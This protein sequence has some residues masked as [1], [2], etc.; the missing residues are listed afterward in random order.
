MKQIPRF[1]YPIL[2]KGGK[3]RN[4]K[5]DLTWDDAWDYDP[6]TGRF[7]EWPEDDDSDQQSPHPSGEKQ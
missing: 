1:D 2:R 6:T 5:R 4:K 3:H 7:P